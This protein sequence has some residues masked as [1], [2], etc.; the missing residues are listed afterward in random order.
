MV[1][2]TH[3]DRP[4]CPRLNGGMTSPRWCGQIQSH[5]ASPA[6][7][8]QTH[9][10]AWAPPPTPQQ[11]LQQFQVHKLRSQWEFCLL[12]FILHTW[13]RSAC[14]IHHVTLMK[15][16]ICKPMALTRTVRTTILSQHIYK[17]VN[18]LHKWKRS[19]YSNL[20]CHTNE[21]C[22][23]VWVFILLFRRCRDGLFC[24]LGF[25][26]YLLYVFTCFFSHLFCT[27]HCAWN[28]AWQQA[29]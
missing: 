17:S 27:V 22:W 3:Q 24:F 2:W 11:N 4:G 6:A 20:P 16:I 26:F 28:L 29:C 25:W 13:S 23:C 18:A 1:F 19:P 5:T 15:I 9:S 8:N 12:P 10:E 21:D 7:H 14:E